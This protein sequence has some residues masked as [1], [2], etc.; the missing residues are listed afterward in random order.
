MKR[1]QQ[2][3]RFFHLI[4][5]NTIHQD[6]FQKID[7]FNEHFRVSFK[8]YWNI[9][10]HLIVD[11]CIQRFINEF[12]V[13]VHISSKSKS[14]NYKIWILVND[15]YVLNWLYHVKNDKKNFVNLNS[16]YVT[17]VHRIQHL[18]KL[19]FLSYHIEWQSRNSFMIKF[20]TYVFANLHVFAFHFD[21]F[22]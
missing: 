8:L 21:I 3:N 11:K 1:W 5:L 9:D 20:S 18:S 19:I 6:V 14:E 13:I 2:I 15:N 17:S 4:L 12:D 7:R 16:V 22:V 10:T